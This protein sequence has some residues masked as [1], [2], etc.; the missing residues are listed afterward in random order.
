MVTEEMKSKHK[1]SAVLV[2][3]M[4]FQSQFDY[5]FIDTRLK[6]EHEYEYSNRKG[7]AFDVLNYGSV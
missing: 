6:Y 4:Q 1:L 7:G 2:A 5:V 3:Y